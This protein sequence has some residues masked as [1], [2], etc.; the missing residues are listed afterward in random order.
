[1]YHYRNMMG[2]G[3]NPTRIVKKTAGGVW[4][5]NAIYRDNLYLGKGSN[6]SWRLQEF[7]NGGS[8]PI[9]VHAAGNVRVDGTAA[10]SFLGMVGPTSGEDGAVAAEVTKLTKWVS[11][12]RA[13][14]GVTG[15]TP[16]T[17]PPP[18]P[19][20]GTLSAPTLLD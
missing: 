6:V 18:P 14:S 8:T 19:T 3:N 7:A 4:L 5:G 1:M 10:Q 9:T 20:S 11:E 12:I 15:S 13:R 17:P 2:G 16:N